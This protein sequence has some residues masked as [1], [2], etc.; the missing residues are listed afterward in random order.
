M[1]TQ[2]T[3]E[4]YHCSQL[5]LHHLTRSI[6][7]DLHSMGSGS[8]LIY[9]LVDRKG[10]GLQERDIQTGFALSLTEAKMRGKWCFYP[11]V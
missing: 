2:Q 5:P 11:Y 10:S 4:M 1:G 9:A 3:V 8:K 7:G 6:K